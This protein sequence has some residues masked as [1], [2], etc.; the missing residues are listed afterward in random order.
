MYKSAIF[1]VAVTG[2]RLCVSGLGML[3]DQAGYRLQIFRGNAHCNPNNR[4]GVH[5]LL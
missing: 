2:R 3:A 1:C 4:T 5:V